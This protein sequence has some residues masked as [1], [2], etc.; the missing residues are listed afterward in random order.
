MNKPW[1]MVLVLAG[2]FIAGGVTGAFVVLRVGHPW[3]ARRGGPDQWPANH[4]KRLSDRLDLRPEQVELIRPIL[5]RNMDELTR[6]RT[7]SMTEARVII[8][9]MEQEISAQL[10]PEQRVKYDL[11]NQ[12]LRER[13]RRFM[14]DR[15]N[16]PP[17]LGGPR[18]EGPPDIPPGGNPP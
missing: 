9:R 6:V 8:R 17:G 14:P 13:V 10:T 7:E 18:P 4:L 5:R 15:P 1:K 3:M 16:R 2:I 12:E 11:L